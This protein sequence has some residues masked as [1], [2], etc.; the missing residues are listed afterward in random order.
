[1]IVRLLLLLLLLLLILV[2]GTLRRRKALVIPFIFPNRP[3]NIGDRILAYAM[4]MSFAVAVA[5]VCVS[6]TAVG[7]VGDRAVSGEEPVGDAG[8]GFL[9]AEGWAENERKWRSKGPIEF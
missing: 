1:M 3:R 2:L 8:E 9:L 4:L 7:V 6:G 5:V